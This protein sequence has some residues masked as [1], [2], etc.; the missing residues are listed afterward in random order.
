MPVD[1]SLLAFWSGNNYM[2][3]GDV[4]GN[5]TLA[6]PAGF[7]PT[8]LPL[9]HGLGYKPFTIFGDEIMDDGVLWCGGYEEE[10][11]GV[12]AAQASF[13]VDDQDLTLVLANSS[14]LAHS[15][16]RKLYYGTYLD[17]GGTD[18]DFLSFFSK[19]PIDKISYIHPTQ[20]SIVNGG[21]S[22]PQATFN[23][24]VAN[25]AT[26]R[27]PNPYGKKCLVRGR[28]SVDGG[29]SWNDLD[30]K[31]R[32]GFNI[33]VTGPGGFTAPLTSRRAGVSIGVD[34]NFIY[35]RTG[36]AYHG[37]VTMNGGTGVS[38]FTPISQTFLIEFVLYTLE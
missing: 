23:Y 11:L 4:F 7:T 9:H 31:I 21:V 38:T 3:R 2:K 17:Y 15:G 34:D 22:S 26:D 25:I 33:T 24:L 30:S 6:V 27:I 5:R 19:H 12:T 28:Y 37:D 35:F 10:R 36:S 32:Y 18:L 29:V 13:F 14:T 20:V 1:P 16:T 8:K